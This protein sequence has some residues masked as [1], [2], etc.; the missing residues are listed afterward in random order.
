MLHS[1]CRGTGCMFYKVAG[2][3]GMY[4]LMVSLCGILCIYSCFLARVIRPCYCKAFDTV[5]NSSLL[6]SARVHRP[7]KLCALC[8][9]MACRMPPCTS[10]T[11]SCCTLPAPRHMTRSDWRQVFDAVSLQPVSNW[12][13]DSEWIGWQCWPVTVD[14]DTVQPKPC[15]TST[16][17]WAT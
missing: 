2:K 14:A 17:S 13:V 6:L 3:V 10:F 9:R 8:G 7:S 16:A 4:G 12:S 5:H 11:G 15:T 1:N